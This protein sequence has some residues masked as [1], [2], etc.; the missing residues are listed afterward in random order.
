MW[1]E[2]MTETEGAKPPARMLFG[3]RRLESREVGVE[4]RLRHGLEHGREEL[5]PVL[6][7]GRR[8]PHVH[9]GGDVEVKDEVAVSN[10]K[11]GAEGRV[12]GDGDELERENREVSLSL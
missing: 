3:V 10:G 4:V 12:L 6:Q 5:H 11:L 9:F 2:D 7:W 8:L 1:V